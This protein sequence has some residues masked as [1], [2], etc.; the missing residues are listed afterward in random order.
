[1]ST[2]LLEQ[3]VDQQFLQ[4]QDESDRDV[5]VV[6]EAEIIADAEL[7]THER[8]PTMF[9]ASS[10]LDLAQVYERLETNAYKGEHQRELDLQY[11]AWFQGLIDK[12]EVNA[13]DD[14]QAADCLSYLR[15]ISA[16]ASAFVEFVELLT[17]KKQ[18][19]RD[20]LAEID[21]GPTNEAIRQIQYG[22][23]WR[24]LKHAARVMG[25]GGILGGVPGAAISFWDPYAEMIS[26]FVHHTTSP[27]LLACISSI[28]FTGLV[29][30]ASGI[31]MYRSGLKARRERKSRYARERRGLLRDYRGIF[32]ECSS[33]V[34]DALARL[35][36]VPAS[37]IRTFERRWSIVEKRLAAEIDSC[38]FDVEDEQS[39]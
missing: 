14:E 33:A 29:S 26:N 3:Q 24:G 5:D 19:V 21:E 12:F 1:M 13:D 23:W 27:T 35:T 28:I 37:R 36:K 2:Q 30:S 20:R 15:A 11:K 16:R 34:D 32:E 17:S 4:D 10:W 39:T 9:A 38:Y 18:H 22:I 6:M 25:L 31:W 8:N 7:Q